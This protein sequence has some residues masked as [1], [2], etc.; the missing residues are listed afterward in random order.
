MILV[1]FF[2]NS[3]PKFAIFEKTILLIHSR[4]QHGIFCL[5]FPCCGLD[6]QFEIG[7]LRITKKRWVESKKVI[8]NFYKTLKKYAFFEK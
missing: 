4:P 2:D 5:F 8:N 6:L 7:Y 3:N 1:P